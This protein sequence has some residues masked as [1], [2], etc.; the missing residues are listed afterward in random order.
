M[1]TDEHSYQLVLD[2]EES[3]GCEI[4]SYWTLENMVTICDCFLGLQIVDQVGANAGL[5][6]ISPIEGE[7]ERVFT[8]A[9]YTEEH[10][11]QLVEDTE[12]SYGCEIS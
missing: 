12:E 5:R 9:I 11:Y 6:T 4:S 1:Y 2:T 8:P 7:E 10:S 3:Y